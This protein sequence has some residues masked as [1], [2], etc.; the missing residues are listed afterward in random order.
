ML[1]RA[2]REFLDDQRLAYDAPSSQTCDIA[3]PDAVAHTLAAGYQAVI[4]CAA[5]TDVDACETNE[6]QA[7]AVNGTGVG[8]LARLCAEQDVPLVQYS[9]DYVFEGTATSPYPT[10]HPRRPL[11]AYGLS[12]A[13]GEELIEEAAGRHLILRTSWLYAPWGK[14]FVRTITRLAAERAMLRVV[15]DQRGRPTACHSLVQASWRLLQQEAQGIYHVTDDGDCTW[16]ELARQ[17]VALTGSRCV[18]EP[19]TTAEFP[20]PATRPAYSVLDL[21]ETAR[22][23]GPLPHW[24][25]TLQQTIERLEPV[26]V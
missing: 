20:R 7:T 13:R 3:R 8:H 10:S 23:V 6:E 25:Q 16:F 12:K 18:V 4:N 19:C 22:L 26:A 21:S 5:Y 2:W 9:T 24:T 17:I 1:G 15:N 11:N 14:N